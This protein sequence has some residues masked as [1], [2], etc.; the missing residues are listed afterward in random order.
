MD[1]PGSFWFWILLVLSLVGTALCWVRVFKSEDS[2]FFK[3]VGLVIAAIPFLGPALFLFLDM[4][5]PIPEDAQAKWEWRIGTTLST[6]IRRQLFKGNRRYAASRLGAREVDGSG[7]SREWKRAT[8]R[9]R[10]VK[11]D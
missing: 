9:A 8:R 6:D 7:G 4:P 5:P 10:K 1:A 11:D 2:V 3:I